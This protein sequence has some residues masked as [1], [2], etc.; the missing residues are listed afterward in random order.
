MATSLSGLVANCNNL[1]I[2]C[3]QNGTAMAMDVNFLNKLF[4]QHLQMGS[5][6]KYSADTTLPC[7]EGDR[8]LKDVIC[9]LL[10]N[11]Q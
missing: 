4:A 10:E 3:I 6:L 2:I 1:H 9:D 7:Y 11:C 8:V 5:Y